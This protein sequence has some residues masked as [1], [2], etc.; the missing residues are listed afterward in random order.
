MRKA[1]MSISGRC[2]YR[3]YAHGGGVLE[4]LTRQEGEGPEEPFSE[5]LP[6]AELRDRL[7]WIASHC[8]PVDAATL[9]GE[10]GFE[11]AE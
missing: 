5:I 11:V 7:D 2:I 9:A 1:W 4:Q 3:L 10:E 8:V 6:H